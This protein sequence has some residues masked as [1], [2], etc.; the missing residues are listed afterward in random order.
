MCAGFT[1]AL[2]A[3]CVAVF[4]A[5]HICESMCSSGKDVEVHRPRDPISHFRDSEINAQRCS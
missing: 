4:S 2:G 3:V 5:C 1:F